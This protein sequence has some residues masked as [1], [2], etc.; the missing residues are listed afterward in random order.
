V[1]RQVLLQLLLRL[2]L[3]HKLIGGDNTSGGP[4]EP[5]QIS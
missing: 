2:A 3:R 4:D 5:E 1:F